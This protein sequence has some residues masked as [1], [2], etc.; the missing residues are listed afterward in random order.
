MRLRL[1]AAQVI[2]QICS[3][4]P[5]ILFEE[6]PFR[7]LF[8][9]ATLE[10]IPLSNTAITLALSQAWTNLF[11]RAKETHF[12]Y[13]LTDL[14][15]SVFPAL[16]TQMKSA[17]MI[18]SKKYGELTDHLNTLVETCDNDKQVVVLQE[19]L[20][21]LMSD[22]HSLFSDPTGS[23]LFENAEQYELYVNNF[24]SIG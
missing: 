2:A 19:S 8:L 6:A 4:T 14:F 22:L 3:A 7:Q 18:K 5:M 20:N 24:C 23:G 12:T 16:L 17:E 21:G 15:A 10:Q 11:E 1:A 13:R 9:Q